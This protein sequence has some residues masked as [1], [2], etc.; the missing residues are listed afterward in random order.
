VGL[1][2]QHSNPRL[3]LVAAGPE[4]MIRSVGIPPGGWRHGYASTPAADHMAAVLGVTAGSGFPGPDLIGHPASTR[5]ISAGHRGPRWPW[6][7]RQAQP[8]RN[9]QQQ[10]QTEPRRSSGGV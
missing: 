4:I 10:W 5:T 9:Q 3:G 1:T 6:P 7:P 2:Y 8:A